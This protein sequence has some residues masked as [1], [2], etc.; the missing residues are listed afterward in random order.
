MLKIIIGFA[1]GYWV[2]LNKEKAREY[3]GKLM[4]YV[5]EKY[6]DITST[7]EKNIE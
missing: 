3:W 4:N 1:I 2:A 7:E 6:K 5:L